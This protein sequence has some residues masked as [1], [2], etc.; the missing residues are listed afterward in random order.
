MK[1]EFKVKTAP[2]YKVAYI[3]RVGPHTNQ[4]MW[5]PELNQ[6]AKWARKNKLRTGKWIMGFL[7]KWSES[8]KSQKRRR[9]I[10]AIEI[11]GTA[12]A[13]GRI[14]LMKIPEQKVV[15]VVFDPDKV[16][17]DIVY[18]ALEAWLEYCPYKQ[19]ARSRELYNGSPWTNPR[20]WANCE[21]QV[22]LKRK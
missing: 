1:V 15:S 19:A 18:Y 5:R 4:N 16:S 9:S 7:D 22:P 20:A 12:K 2:S 21:I 3:L 13:E 14:Q 10:A 17:A 11:K 6:L 8:E